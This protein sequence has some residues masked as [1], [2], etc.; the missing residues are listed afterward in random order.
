MVYFD[1]FFSIL[2]R[3]V[4]NIII[5]I[6]PDNDNNIALTIWNAY[7]RSSLCRGHVSEVV[8][9]VVV[10]VGHFAIEY[11]IHDGTLSIR[12]RNV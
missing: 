6:V 2:C 8:A 4:P 1:F 10:V 11:N 7:L 5:S 12:T 3:K 9:I